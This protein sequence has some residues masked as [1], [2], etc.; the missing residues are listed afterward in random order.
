MTTKTFRYTSYAL[1]VLEKLIGANFTVTGVKKLPQGP[2]I[3]VANHFTRSETFFIPYLINKYTDRKVRSL[4][5]SGLF[6]G[7]LGEF[8]TSLGTL[9][10]K[11]PARNKII[12]RDL[13]MGN[14]D[15]MIYPEG[16]MIK[17]KQVDHGEVFVS[18]TPS[19]VGPIRT[20]SAVLGLQSQ[21]YRQD[22]IKAFDSGKNDIL[23][24]FEKSHNIEYKDDLRALTTYVV[25]LTITY[26]PLRPGLNSIQKLAEKFVKKIP[27]SIR[28]ELEI[29][30]NFLLNAE[31]NMNFGDPINLAEY[32]ALSRGSIYQ[33]PIIQYETKTNLVIRYLKSRLTNKFMEQI[34]NN[35]QINFDH[36]FSFALNEIKAEKVEISHLKNIIYLSA[37]MIQKYS[38]YTMHSSIY[39]ENLWKMLSGEP[40][41]EFD[42]VFRLAQSLNVIKN[43]TSSSFVINKEMLD[44]KY[45]FHQIRL[46]NPFSVICN[47]FALTDI[48][49]R[50]VHRN[51]SINVKLMRQK[52]CEE[53]L[54]RDVKNF[55][56]DYQQYFDKK[57]S[58]EKSVGEPFFLNSKTRA[59]ASV[60]KVGILLV[61]GY[62]SAPGEVRPLAKYLNKIGFKIYAVRLKGH[63]TAPIN[64]KDVSWQDWYD[65]VQ[66]GYSALASVCDR[67]FVV[68][69]STGGLLSLLTSARKGLNSKIAGIVAINAAIKLRDIR[70][71]LVSGINVWNELMDK[72]HIE[73]TKLEYIE[74]KPE[75]PSI[76]YSQNYLKGVEELRDL[77]AVCEDNL[78]KVMHRSLIIQATHDPVVDPKSGRIIYDKISAREKF[79]SEV[80]FENHVIINGK[81]QEEIFG[82]IGKFLETA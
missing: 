37:S 20:G 51:C 28:E 63:G 57:L 32:V 70:S 33:I 62:K 68:G 60:K 31:I 26:Y 52:I 39:E 6:H 49:S 34:Y 81:G 15:W 42:E 75:N 65:S 46:K 11:D 73:K 12:V 79:I 77:M 8:L 4:A 45:D 9:S 71:H 40:H 54:K 5:D 64:I 1:R 69:F 58:K 2:I 16:S 30:G 13:V 36:L 18:H 17:S 56:H 43:V 59:K 55:D 38:R 19:R 76:N 61:H 21:L 27:D 80:N 82:I 47:E 66:V 53:M 3:F 41:R 44:K 10:V 24:Y 29:E 50:I 35:I 23:S 74:N 78:D 25:P 72:F 7:W 67:V 22:I 48:P 14:C